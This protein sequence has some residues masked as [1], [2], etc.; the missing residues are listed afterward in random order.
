MHGRVLLRFCSCRMSVAS[1]AM[2][3]HGAAIRTLPVTALRYLINTARKDLADQAHLQLR[4]LELSC[5]ADHSFE[6]DHSM[7]KEVS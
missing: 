3:G 4:A 1:Q 6:L 2:L 7:L 5:L